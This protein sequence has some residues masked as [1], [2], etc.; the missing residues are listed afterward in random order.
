[1]ITSK[2][3]AHSLFYS[4]F[5]SRCLEKDSKQNSEGSY[6]CVHST[7]KTRVLAHE[8][9]EGIFLF[10]IKSAN[11]LVCAYSIHRILSERCRVMNSY[12]NL[13]K[14][15]ET[16]KTELKRLE[17]GGLIIPKEIQQKDNP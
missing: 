17:D 10:E 8:V 1:M 3:V 16:Y 13:E 9:Q 14:T 12:K 6:Q 7:S 11:N 4:I 5:G 2:M 15:L